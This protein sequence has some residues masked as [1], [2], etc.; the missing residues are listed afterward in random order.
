MKKTLLLFLLLSSSVSFA[1]TATAPETPKERPN[2]NQ[3]KGILK[4][5]A[6]EAV[7]GTAKQA[8][9][10]A[11]K[12]VIT[13]PAGIAT[14]GIIIKKTVIDHPI[15]TTGAVVAGGVTANH[16][17]NKRIPVIVEKSKEDLNHLDKFWDH[18]KTDNDRKNALISHTVMK[19][20][21]ALYADR[22]EYN[23]IL[24]HLEIDMDDE[25][26]FISERTLQDQEDLEKTKEF[27]IEYAKLETIANDLDRKN[28]KKCTLQDLQKIAETP[29]KDFEKKFPQAFIIKQG[30][31]TELY[32]VNSYSKLLGEKNVRERD[33]IPSYNA[34]E[35]FLKNKGIDF[36]NLADTDGRYVN[37]NNNIT[38]FN[39][40][41]HLH[42]D[43]RTT[44]KRNAY[45]STIDSID[46]KSL[47]F[48]TIKDFATLLILS[49]IGDLK[50]NKTY[51]AD[52]VKIFN[53]FETIYLRNK[54]LC[55]YDL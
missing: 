27:A 23:K 55:L 29:N 14:A 37:L 24:K 51:K 2:F 30:N 40:P 45:L 32:A 6:G 5:A 50:K 41:Y 19:Y 16:L 48:A 21:E 11:G 49:S 15:L 10:E 7:K 34:I 47:R 20:E 46:A 33:H 25:W 12:R 36:K 39:L 52:Y 54:Q 26:D 28:P 22:L 42:R 31:K 13:S 17:W 8:A 9:K 3:L 53:G 4:G 44:G 43:N 35:L 18:E 1:N 38:A